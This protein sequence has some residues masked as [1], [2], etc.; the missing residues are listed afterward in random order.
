M[1]FTKFQSSFS[2]G[3]IL[4]KLNAIL[5]SFEIDF[6][7]EGYEIRI[8]AATLKGDVNF[9]I[10]IFTHPKDSHLSVVEFQRRKGDR[11]AYREFYCLIRNKMNSYIIGR[12]SFQSVGIKGIES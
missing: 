4:K 11:E 9:V 5:H 2:P 7:E 12:E 10:N 1:V 8:N 6:I 3:K